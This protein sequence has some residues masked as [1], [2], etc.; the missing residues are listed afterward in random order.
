LP[1]QH[2]PL[3]TTTTTANKYYHHHPAPHPYR[4]NP[5]PT[6]IVFSEAWWVGT[7]ADNP[8]E[9]RLDLPASLSATPIHDAFDYGYGA[10]AKAD[11]GTAAPLARKKSVGGVGG[12]QQAAVR[13]V[14]D[15]E[16][17]GSQPPG[18]QRPRRA[19]AVQGKRRYNDD[20]GAE[21][22]GGW[23]GGDS[24]S[25][26]S[27]LVVLKRGGS[28]KRCVWVLRGG[29]WGWGWG[30]APVAPVCLLP[31]Q[32]FADNK[33]V[34]NNNRNQYRQHADSKQAQGQPGYRQL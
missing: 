23:D 18:S 29:G 34:L 27:G 13:G 21:S 31:I 28:A 1:I 14:E 9:K 2:P 11:E 20:S 22:E 6:Q 33:A 26:G 4:P 17:G 12:S 10:G 30:F 15:G 24:G 19:A 7:K 25:E 8:E 32:S 16:P 5:T 3:P